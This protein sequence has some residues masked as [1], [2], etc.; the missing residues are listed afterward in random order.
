MKILWSQARLAVAALIAL[1]FTSWPA[2]WSSDP[3]NSHAKV[4]L[5]RG[6]DSNRPAQ[7]S[8]S[9][10]PVQEGRPLLA[11]LGAD[12]WH[13][14]GYRGRGMKVAILDSGF[15]GYRDHLGKALPLDVKVRSFRKDGNLEAKNSQHGILCGE[16]VHA[17]APEAELLFANWEADDPEQ[18]LTAAR[19]ARQQ[20]ARIISCS[21]IMPSWSDGEGGGQ[22]HATLAGIL[23]SGSKPDDVLCFACAGNIAERHWSGVYH[24]GGHG[25]HEWRPRHDFNVM[26]PWGEERASA[27][28]YW[29]TGADYDLSVYD[30]TTDEE[31]G[32]SAAQPGKERNS[33]V[34]KFDAQPE[35]SYQVRVHLAR[36]RAGLFHLAAL[37]ANLECTTTP[38]SI[39]FPGDGPE[40]IAVGAVDQE[41][42]R[43]AYSSCG[44]NSK[45]PK[46]DL[47]APVPFPSSVRS[48]AF[49]GTSAATPQ[50]AALAAL[51]WSSHP[52]WSAQRVRSAL[53]SSAQDL[54]PP[55]PDSETGYGL[56]Q[57]PRLDVAVRTRD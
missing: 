33:A 39:C 10:L 22:V 27:E 54:G 18:F 52:D 14:A 46:P 34:V 6:I 28:L 4:A 53:Y 55:G 21:I 16:V 37:N 40:V 23:G 3:P 25:F 9:S 38:S 30:A 15:R 12:R 7:A 29:Q 2:A 47:V 31:V 43:L 19:W 13:E 48:R 11:Q 26:T 36:G 24:D 51:W 42:R 17:L 49:G 1:L 41:G 32:H 20:G 8:A 5:L 45:Q 57:L 50:A 35:R 56:I 44:P